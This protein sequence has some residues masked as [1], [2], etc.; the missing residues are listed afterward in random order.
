MHRI[1]NDILGLTGAQLSHSPA[2]GLAYVAV[3][4]SCLPA[5]HPH[6]SVQSDFSVNVLE[7]QLSLTEGLIYS[8]NL[9]D[10]LSFCIQFLFFQL[11]HWNLPTQVSVRGSNLILLLLLCFSRFL[12]QGQ[13]MLQNFTFT[14]APHLFQTSALEKKSGFFFFLLLLTYGLFI[15]KDCFPFE[16]PIIHSCRLSDVWDCG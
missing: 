13:A 7:L 3:L 12:P 5:L 4:N 8:S 14:F 11:F 10:F 6:Y 2:P 16:S 1:S 15:G 9:L